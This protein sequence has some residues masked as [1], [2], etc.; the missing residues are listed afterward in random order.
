[1]Q[2]IYAFIYALLILP[3]VFSLTTLAA[4]DSGE[5]YPTPIERNPVPDGH[6]KIF[7]TPKDEA[8]AVMKL[9]LAREMR[10]NG[11]VPAT[12]A[13][14][15]FP[16]LSI[17][18]DKIMNLRKADGPT[19]FNRL[20]SLA[21]ENEVMHNSKKN[22]AKPKTEL[23]YSCGKKIAGMSKPVQHNGHFYKPFL[24]RPEMCY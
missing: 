8:S 14:M 23:V 11:L 7:R 10:F 3:V 9:M 20:V 22:S 24:Q 13:M 5:L 17:I 4:I 21:L 19:N 15:E 16:A 6:D 1:M 12:R 2:K 18:V